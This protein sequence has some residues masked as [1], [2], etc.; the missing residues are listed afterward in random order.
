MQI[1]NPS[2]TSLGFTQEQLQ[3]AQSVYKMANAGVDMGVVTGKNTV[4][5][6]NEFQQ[7]NG[8]GILLRIGASGTTEQSYKWTTS[9]SAI[10]INHGLNRQPIGFFIV[11]KDKAVDV[12]RTAVPTDINI[13]LAPTDAT[14][15]VTIYIF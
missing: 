2:G 1:I 10:T 6:Y 5:V 7:G 3:W 4:G 13:K 12:Y 11:D 8:T 9:N 15:N 14:V